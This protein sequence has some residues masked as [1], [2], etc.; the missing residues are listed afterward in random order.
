MLSSGRGPAALR[1]PGS[2]AWRMTSQLRVVKRGGGAQA[3]HIQV[4]RIMPASITAAQALL[5]LLLCVVT[6]FLCPKSAIV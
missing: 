5:N 2:S 1:L 3:A 6:D 4:L